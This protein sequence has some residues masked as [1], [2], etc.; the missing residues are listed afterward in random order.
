[1]NGIG[2]QT[3]P[4]VAFVLACVREA[5]ASTA[6]DVAETAASVQD[7]TEV[8]RLAGRNRVTAFVLRAVRGEAITIPSAAMDSL[9][10]SVV[11][12]V[13]RQMVV[14]TDLERAARALASASILVMALK[15]PGLARTVYPERALRPY[16]DIDLAVEGADVDRVAAVLEAA[17]FGEIARTR[18]SNVKSRDFVAKLSLTLLELHRDSLQTGL[19][20]RCEN[21]RWRRA[22]PIPGMTGLVML[23]P[24]DQL[25]HLSYHAHKHGFNRLVWLKDIDMVTRGTSAG[26]DWDLVESVSRREALQSS[27]WLAL[28]FARALLGTPVPPGLLR[29]LEPAPTTRALFR[30]AWPPANVHALRGHMRRRAVQLDTAESWRGKIASVVFMGRRPERVRLLAQHIRLGSGASRGAAVGIR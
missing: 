17:E 5:S 12:S 29:S 28:D 14:D 22:L 20:P 15:G 16:D 1:M 21:D 4:E 27:V 10:D 18:T 7:W 11:E 3:S 25:V 19:P 8:V 23:A 2:F 13:A 9:V 30:L 6:S 24:E 26:F